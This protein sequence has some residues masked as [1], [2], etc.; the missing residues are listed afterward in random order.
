MAKTINLGNSSSDFTIEKSGTNYVLADG[1]IFSFANIVTDPGVT[2]SNIELRL[3][4]AM[5]GRSNPIE[6]GSAGSKGNAVIV[7]ETGIVDATDTAI[8]MTGRNSI[9]SNRGTIFATDQAASIGIAIEGDDAKIINAG[10]LKAHKGILVDGDGNSVV[11]SGFLAMHMGGTSIT[12]ASEAGETNRFVNKGYIDGGNAVEGGDGIEKIINRAEMLGDI[13]VGGGDDV[14]V[15]SRAING[16]V[17][18]GLGNDRA[19]IRDKGDFTDIYGDAG[20]DVF[21]LRGANAIS[22]GTTIAGGADDDTFIVSRGDFLLKELGGGG[23]DTIKSTISFTLANEFENL[24][25]IGNKTI[26]GNGN[27]AANVITGN[28]AKNTILGLAGTDTLDGGGGNDILFGGTQADTFVFRANAGKDLISDFTDMSDKID[29]SNYKGIDGFGDLAG[30]IDQKGADTVI[31]LLDG[32][33]I[34]LENFTATN[35][36]IAD[37][38]F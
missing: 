9:V 15:T 38:E 19:V 17:Y 3:D 28:A 37:F 6:I 18:L 35:L 4:G 20:D 16:D 27:A 24:V 10:F 26:D 13:A 34:T 36:T 33:R 2:I 12:F 23:E 29:L 22:S 1:D 8:S 5:T 31:T 14:L 21:D 32:D 30:H 25:L 7:G 11:N